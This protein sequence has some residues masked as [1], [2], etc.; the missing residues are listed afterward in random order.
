ML[1]L[2]PCQ[3]CIPCLQVDILAYC[4]KHAAVIPTLLPLT[5]QVLLGLSIVGG[6]TYAAAR[7][8]APAVGGWYTRLRDAR[9]SA[10][11]EAAERDDALTDAIS[12]MAA[13]QAALAGAVDSLAGAVGGGEGESGGGG[14]GRGGSGGGQPPKE[15]GGVSGEETYRC[16]IAARS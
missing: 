7:V 15:G 14:G 13:A 12:R 1:V 4:M 10:A 5:L 16:A 8:V 3:A 11:A 9:A 2:R 6:A